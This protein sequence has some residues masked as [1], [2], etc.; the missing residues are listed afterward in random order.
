M[1]IIVIYDIACQKNYAKV[2][3]NIYDICKKYLIHVQKSVFE[4]E[5]SLPQLESLK[6]E[7][8]KYLRKDIDSF[9]LFKSR[10]EK[11]LNKEFLTNLKT[12]DIQFI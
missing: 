5:L 6:I 7:V 1:Y 8:K 11:W 9:I 12:E 3:K 10:N 2:S 4:G